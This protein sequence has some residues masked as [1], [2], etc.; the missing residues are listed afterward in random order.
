MVIEILFLKVVA[1]HE[2]G[3]T[4][5]TRKEKEGGVVEMFC[6][7]IGVIVTKYTHLYVYVCTCVYVN[8]THQT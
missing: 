4:R 5:L 7:L 6:N 1:W 2:N 8:Q 3:E